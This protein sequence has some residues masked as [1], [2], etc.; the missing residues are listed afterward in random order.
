MNLLKSQIREKDRLLADL[1]AVSED[2][3]ARRAALDYE[4]IL[5]ERYRN[6]PSFKVWN[7]N[8][9]L[10]RQ[11]F[12][13]L[14]QHRRHFNK[15]IRTY[16][17]IIAAKLTHV[18]QDGEDGYFNKLERNVG[19]KEH[20]TPL[21]FS[22]YPYAEKV[23]RCGMWTHADN[24]RRCHKTDVCPLCLWNDIL[25]VRVQA[26]GQ[27]SGTFERMQGQGLTAFFITLGYTT[28]PA[29]SKSVGRDFDAEH[30]VVGGG[31]PQYD[32]YPVC[33]GFNADDTTLPHLGYWGANV[34]SLIAQEAIEKV[35]NDKLL[36][37]Y[38]YKLEAKFKIV[39][40]GANRV[41]IHAHI[42][43]NGPEGNAQFL[44]DI[45]FRYMRQGLCCYRKHMRGDYH[46]DVLVERLNCA[47][48]LEKCICYSEKIISVGH[49]VGEAMANPKAKR[50]D[51]SWDPNYVCEVWTGFMRLINDDIPA[52]L[53]R[54]SF[55]KILHN[56]R[57]RKTVGNFRFSDRGTCIGA[58]PAWHKKVRRKK[59]K[60]DRAARLRRKKRALVRATKPSPGRNGRARRKAP[61]NAPKGSK[62]AR[63]R[64]ARDEI[65][66]VS[67]HEPAGPPAPTGVT[68][69]PS[70]GVTLGA[71]ER[72]HA[73]ACAPSQ[74]ENAVVNERQSR[75]LNNVN[76]MESPN[77]SQTP[78]KRSRDVP[79]YGLLGAERPQDKMNRKTIKTQNDTAPKAPDGMN[80]ASTPE[81]QREPRKPA[82]LDLDQHPHYNVQSTIYSLL[83]SALNMSEHY[84][85]YPGA[86]ERQQILHR[87]VGVY[88]DTV[89]LLK[90][91]ALVA[92][93]HHQL[94]FHSA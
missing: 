81:P 69:A 61:K 40:N 75:V 87:I 31:D 78:T 25:K 60:R 71:T 48:H 63:K 86:E 37:G 68:T 36:A 53:T 3:K 12:D 23:V 64:A 41:N 77:F 73:G 16:L 89:E 44:A 67:Q 21:I 57:R 35:Y 42:V 84:E 28:Q 22:Q 70:E 58:E 82:D 27:Q 6:D 39:P 94:Q 92:R 72:R 88:Q 66:S 26:F 1:E 80:K 24:S 19:W 5:E 51:G 85:K 74:E 62:N 50:G 32:P 18:R 47:A 52:I 14:F 4:D 91:Q 11:D 34:L 76:K 79:F 90:N 83:L 30:I 17:E 49:I 54:L 33:L 15:I 13:Y 65:P 38:I 56:L 8:R 46:P 43:A 10:N 2:G 9:A 59:S 55:E 45:L 20:I 7:R 29:N 93:V